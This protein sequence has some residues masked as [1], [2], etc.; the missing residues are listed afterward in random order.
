[1]VDNVIAV[2]ESP[3]RSNNVSSIL[4][5]DTCNILS[6]IFTNFLS[7]S[8]LGLTISTL[9][10]SMYGSG[11]AFLS[12]LPLGVCGNLSNLIKYWGTIYSGNFEYKTVFNTDLLTCPFST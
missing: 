8:F 12:T 11:N 7:M 4:T 6:I 9:F 5:F 2:N 3:P 1:M 10:S